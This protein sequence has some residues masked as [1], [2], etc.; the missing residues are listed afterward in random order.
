MKI[1]LVDLA[2]AMLATGLCLAGVLMLSA[3]GERACPCCA[4]GEGCPREAADGCP[5]GP[6]P[7]APA[8]L[9]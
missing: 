8:V 7:S 3:A 2:L 5:A 4:S 9:P 1:R 6:T